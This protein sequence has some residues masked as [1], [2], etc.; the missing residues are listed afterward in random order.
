MRRTVLTIFALSLF[1][2]I[3]VDALAQTT[4]GPTKIK[5]TATNG[6]SLEVTGPTQLDGALNGTSASFSGNLVA[7]T[8]NPAQTTYGSYQDTNSLIS[9]DLTDPRW[10]YFPISTANSVHVRQADSSLGG[11]YNVDYVNFDGAASGQGVMLHYFT[12]PAGTTSVTVSAPM[13]L[14]PSVGSS[15]VV[16]TLSS[17]GNTV[18][19]KIAIALTSTMQT[20]SISGNVTPGGQYQ[21]IL[22]FNNTGVGSSVQ[23]QALIGPVVATPTGSTDAALSKGFVRYNPS[24]FNWS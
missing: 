19:A 10:S 22:Y 4:Q 14:P 2:L 12:V 6:L 1:M 23:A 18:V 15:T 17:L 20:Y 8:V 16:M 24:P 7:G 21:V 11:F 3:P 13:S 5:G 9:G